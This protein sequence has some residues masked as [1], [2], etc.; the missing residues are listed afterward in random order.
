MTQHKWTDEQQAVIQ[1]AARPS[2]SSLMIEA[3]A[4][5][6]KTTTLGQAGQGIKL[7]GIAL[8]FAVENKKALERALPSNFTV[9]SFNGLGH[10]AWA[11]G[12][13]SQTLS[14][15]DS[16][17]TG[18]LITQAVKDAKTT[19]D[20]TQ[21]GAARDLVKLAMQAGLVPQGD[22]FEHNSLLEDSP[23]NWLALAAE[24][25]AAETDQPM[26]VDLA[27][28]ALV[29]G[30]QLARQGQIS[31]DDQIY[32]SSLLGGR[33]PQFPV[34]VVDED[35]DLSP[36]QIRMLGQALRPGGRLLAVGDR[37]QAIYA[38]RGASGNAAELIR[39]HRS[40]WLDLPLMT[41]FRCPKA[42]VAR[43]QSHVPGY[44]AAEGNPYGDVQV[45]EEPLAL[46][47]SGLWEPEAWD[48]WS[49]R[50]V[51]KAAQAAA[52]GDRPTVA[53]V[54]RN[55][56]PLIKLAFKLLRTGVG[57]EMLG[58]DIGRALVA[59]AKKILPEDGTP[60]DQCAGLIEAWRLGE[61]S[62]AQANGHE[63]KLESIGDRAGALQATL[64]GAD[65]R[66]AGNL[67]AMLARLFSREGGQITLSSIHR[68]KGLEYDLVIHLDP[69]RIPS[70][71]ARALGGVVLEQEF[72]ARYVA[73]TRTRHTLVLANV[74]DFQATRS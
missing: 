42:V 22:A 25:E 56:A 51:V 34:A 38:W 36:L 24:T 6:A 58:R 67:R 10:G 15:P 64:E 14:A 16:R 50:D 17:K 65:C 32:C 27:H 23:E 71:A 69:W 4:G 39:K 53:V 73:E 19:L 49:Y 47:A 44:K 8:T 70:K 61:A 3:G 72:N 74:G 7:P 2:G 9:K 31:F 35:Q 66:D 18:K 13:P 46:G 11:R 57:V 52:P 40:D 43:Q 26:L 54:C 41:T 63:E 29:T 62:L 5:C 1:A 21:W 59:L 48:G 45:W 12:G 33:F 55:N 37:R 68:V 60:R 28:R 30:I 20:E